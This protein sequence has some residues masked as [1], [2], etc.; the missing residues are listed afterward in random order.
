MNE[1]KIVTVS[2]HVLEEQSPKREYSNI[3]LVRIRGVAEQERGK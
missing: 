2:A 3:E 1:T